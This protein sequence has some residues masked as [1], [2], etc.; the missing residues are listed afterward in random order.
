[1]K[2]QS[3]GTGVVFG[4]AGLMWAGLRN[5]LY[6]WFVASIDQRVWVVFCLEPEWS[7]KLLVL[8]S[9]LDLS[10]TSP[11]RI[12]LLSSWCKNRET[13]E[14]IWIFYIVARTNILLAEM[15]C[16]IATPD[17]SLSA[18]CFITG[19]WF[20]HQTLCHSHALNRSW[21]TTTPVFLL[22]SQ[23]TTICVSVLVKSKIKS[24]MWWAV[25]SKGGGVK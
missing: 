23:I 10:D 21:G 18:T 7:D 20:T 15:I 9:Q 17:R 8:M 1:M 12:D 11:L 4:A 3:P 22:R 14:W 5:K 6:Y 16:L 2:A 13:N 24:G 19:G 25:G